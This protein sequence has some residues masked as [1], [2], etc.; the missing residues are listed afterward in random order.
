MNVE[1]S[2]S[3]QKYEKYSSKLQRSKKFKLRKQKCT[4][5]LTY[6]STKHKK[7]NNINSI[8]SLKR[9]KNQQSILIGRIKLY[10]NKFLE[11]ITFKNSQQLIQK[12]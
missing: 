6:I 12:G 1:I 4:E 8:T 7:K 9:L 10:I 5:L 11:E 3:R 2:E